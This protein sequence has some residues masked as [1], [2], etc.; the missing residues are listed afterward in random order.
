M[1]V[2][3]EGRCGR[4]AAAVVALLLVGGCHTLFTQSIRDTGV[5]VDQ[6]KLL[7]YY[8]CS[9]VT[10][11]RDVTETDTRVAG[12]HAL[13]VRNGRSID[14][15]VFPAGTVGTVVA[16]GRNWVDVK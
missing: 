10:L 9:E 7:R 13:T 5:T 2:P 11:A 12:T 8:L 4:A 16:T 1:R 14:Y 3:T 15:I 6:L